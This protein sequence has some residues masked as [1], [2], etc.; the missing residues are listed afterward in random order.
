MNESEMLEKKL[1]EALAERNSAVNGM[2]DLK[3]TN[4]MLA[5]QLIK[6]ADALAVLKK[7]ELIGFQCPICRET[8]GYPH[9]PN[10]KLWQVLAPRELVAPKETLK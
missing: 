9:K 2:L 6:Y 4:Q 1:A 7:I 10:C 8:K 3:R 5:E